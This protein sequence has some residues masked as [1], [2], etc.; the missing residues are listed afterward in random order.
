MDKL[1]DYKK[2]IILH[3]SMTEEDEDL[4]VTIYTNLSDGDRRLI[5]HMMI[6]CNPCE[7]EGLKKEM[8]S[9]QNDLM[10]RWVGMISELFMIKKRGD[11]CE[12]NC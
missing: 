2:E 6:S 9:A 10:S 7:R 5:D 4:F 1:K 12:C 8:V 11:V 3:D